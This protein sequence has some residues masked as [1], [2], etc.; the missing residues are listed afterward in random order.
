VPAIRSDQAHADAGTAVQVQAS[1]L[2]RGHGE[3]T[4]KV[5][6]QRAYDRALG[7]QGVHVAQQDVELDPAD[8]HAFESD[9]SA[10]IA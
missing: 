2:G 5:G 9:R 10:R 8:P 7:L 4:S 6:N 3:R 1:G